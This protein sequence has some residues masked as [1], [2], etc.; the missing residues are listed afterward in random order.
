M[1]KL[2]NRLLSTFRGSF[3]P[4]DS[5]GSGGVVTSL[6]LTA[7]AGLTGGG[8]LTTNRT[9]NVVAN[10]D[11]SIVV[12]AND[13]QV[14]ILATDAQHGNLGGD[15]LHDVVT[16]LI[17]GFMSAVDKTTFDIFFGAPPSPLAPTGTTQTLDWNDGANQA[18]DLSS[19]LGAVTLTLTNPQAG[20]RYKLKVIQAV[21]P[22]TLIFSPVPKWPGGVAPVITAVSG[23]I[24]IIDLFFDGTNYYG[25]FAQAFA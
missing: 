17:D 19:A 22:L 24:D 3:N 9:F 13:I 16:P 8:N 1:A 23:A 4:S 15:T 6:T 5:A 12:N 21:V 18:L 11:G 10:A 2:Q 14:G 25:T 7:G 20:G